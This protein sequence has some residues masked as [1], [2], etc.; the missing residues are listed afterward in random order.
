MS[1]NDSSG[2][3]PTPPGTGD[4]RKGAFIE[5]GT[6]HGQVIGSQEN[7]GVSPR[8][9][10]PLRPLPQRPPSRPRCCS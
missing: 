8:P 5:G 2:R 6:F 7:H 10:R 1:N 9:P 4:Q 3:T